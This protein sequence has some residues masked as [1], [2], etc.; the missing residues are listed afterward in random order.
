V[1]QQVDKVGVL[2]ERRRRAPE[3]VPQQLE[4]GAV[5]RAEIFRRRVLQLPGGQR[6][7]GAPAARFEDADHAQIEDKGQAWPHRM[8]ETIG[9]LIRTRLRA[10]RLAQLLQPTANRPGEHVRLGPLDRRRVGQRLQQHCRRMLAIPRDRAAAAGGQRDRIAFADIDEHAVGAHPRPLDQGDQPLAAL[11][12]PQIANRTA[13][14]VGP[15]FVDL[16][17]ETA[18]DVAFVECKPPGQGNGNAK[19]CGI[20]QSIVRFMRWRDDPGG[21]PPSLSTNAGAPAS[22]RLPSCPSPPPRSPSFTESELGATG[23]PQWR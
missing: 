1:Q 10:G 19:E 11:I 5:G 21:H 4:H 6:P 22:F 23:P 3:P 7:V 13:P 9:D 20:G 14:L 8:I 12:G 15:A 16:A 17:V 18:P 2:R